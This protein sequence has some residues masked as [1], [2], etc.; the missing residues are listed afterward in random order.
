MLMKKHLK[1]IRKIDREQ[2]KLLDGL[3]ARKTVGIDDKDDKIEKGLQGNQFL[4][5]TGVRFN[6]GPVFCIGKL[7]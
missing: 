6:V 2:L 7:T 1:N 3:S 5:N 4:Q